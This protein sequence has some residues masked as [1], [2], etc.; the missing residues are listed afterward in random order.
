M[1]SFSHLARPS[2]RPETQRHLPRLIAFVVSWLALAACADLG[3]APPPER[4]RSVR[5]VGAFVPSGVWSDLAVLLELEERV[6]RPFDVAHWFTSWDHAFDHG[7][8][9]AL[10]AAGRVPLISW[11][12]HRQGVRDIAAGRYDDY[13]RSWAEGVRE[14]PGL[15]YL[16]PFPEMNGDWVSWNG[17]PDGLR[18]AWTRMTALF[19]AEGADNVRWV[20]S[21]N[22][23]D[24]PRTDANRMER[25]YPG[26]AHVDVFG[27]S[28]YNW[29]ETRPYIGWR[30]FAQILATPYERLTALGPHP[31]WM[32][33]TASSEEGGDKADWIRDMF[34]TD[35]FPMLEAIIWFNEAKEA[36]WRLE[37]SAAALEAF[38]EAIGDLERPLPAAA[39]AERRPFG[40]FQ[41]H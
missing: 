9:H 1:R 5:L 30:T 22:V 28:G 36:D 2:A 6:G 37:S 14:A 39:R 8:V 11:Q 25:Y 41:L 7:P 34:A 16:R 24:E 33:E 27:L 12:P 13:I 17:D 31:V 4:E 10:L 26:D 20:W 3:T 29:G 21:P 23:S 18:A 19:A 38:A 40:R 32:T 15:V 35:G